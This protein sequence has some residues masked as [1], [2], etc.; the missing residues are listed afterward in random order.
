MSGRRS[1][2]RV[3]LLTQVEERREN[4]TTLGWTKDISLGGLSISTQQTLAIGTTVVVRFGVPG[5]TRAVEAAGRVAWVVPGKSM[6]IGFLGLIEE[7][8]KSIADY[9]ATLPE[10]SEQEAAG[11]SFNLPEGRRRSARLPRK[12]S[13]TLLWQDV[14][15]QQQQDAAE[16]V[17]VSQYGAMVLTFTPLQ[18]GRLVWVVVPAMNHKK[19]LARVAWV[20]TATRTG[21]VEMGLELLGA[22]N[23]WEI[24]FPAQ[25]TESEEPRPRGKRR[26]AR[27]EQRQPVIINWEDEWGRAREEEAETW[28]ICQYGALLGSRV[29]LPARQVLRVRMPELG[30]EAEARVVHARPG[31]V[32]GYT[33]LGIEF[34]GPGEFWGVE[35]PPDDWSPGDSEE[36]GIENPVSPGAPR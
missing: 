34:I 3:P 13:V 7:D 18:V 35:F 9:V 29:A 15:G 4:F 11:K 28:G 20:N 19:E 6:G 32:P 10:L 8:R 12:I 27:L 23:F 26:S 17:L 22:E 36:T 5:R 2:P 14:H 21:R 33:D 1:V 30:R 31:F 24:E 25:G 16:T